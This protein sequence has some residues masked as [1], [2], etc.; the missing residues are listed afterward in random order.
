M[1][2]GAAASLL[3]APG[4]RSLPQKGFQST[5]SNRESTIYLC[6]VI[7]N[8]RVFTSGRRDLARIATATRFSINNQQSKIN[9]HKSEIANRKSQI[10]N[11]PSPYSKLDPSI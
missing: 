8:A 2:P 7:P 11:L 5:I 3:A 6:C 1:N 4:K 9:N 10:V